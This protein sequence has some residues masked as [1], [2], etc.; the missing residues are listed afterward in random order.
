MSLMVKATIDRI[1]MLTIVTCW[2]RRK[3]VNGELMAETL[4][5]RWILIALAG[6]T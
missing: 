5:E 3:N 2:L 6:L 1:T 4:A